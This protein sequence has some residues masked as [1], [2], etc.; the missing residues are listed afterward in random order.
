VI[1]E[2]RKVL[3]EAAVRQIERA[4]A[5]YAAA[6]VRVPIA[7]GQ[8]LYLDIGI[9]EDLQDPIDAVRWSPLGAGLDEGGV[10]AGPDEPSLAGRIGDMSIPIRRAYLPIAWGIAGPVWTRRSTSCRRCTLQRPIGCALT[11]TSRPTLTRCSPRSSAR[12]STHG[13]SGRRR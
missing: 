11:R 7:D 10:G 13:C 8:G 9:N 5:E 3:R 4:L 12:R 2:V 1:V 6:T